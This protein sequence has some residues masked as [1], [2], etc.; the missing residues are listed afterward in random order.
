MQKTILKLPHADRIDTADR[1]VLEKNEKNN[2]KRSETW[3][4]NEKSL[5]ARER[6]TFL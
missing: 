4:N 6:E 3:K 5:K 1:S 2:H